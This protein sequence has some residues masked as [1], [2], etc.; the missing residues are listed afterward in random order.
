MNRQRKSLCL[1][2]LIHGLLLSSLYAVSS[3]SAW[4]SAP[5]VIDFSVL[6]GAGPVGAPGPLP[7]GPAASRPAARSNPAPRPRAMA[8]QPPAP[9]APK[10]PPSPALEQPGPAAIVAPQKREAV[11]AARVDGPTNATVP[12]GPSLSSGRGGGGASGGGSVSGS[13]SGGGAGSGTGGGSGGGATADQLRNRYLKEHFAYIRDLIQR[14]ISYP[15]RAR[16]FGWAGKVVVTF[17]VHESGRVSNE[18]VIAS[19]G[20]ELLD[21]N[22]IGTIRDVSPFPKP[23]VK[24]ELRIPIVYRLD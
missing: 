13:G 16:K 17:I 9:V 14:S 22:V 21:N 12:V 19:S 1:S 10:A 11:A 7:A 4:Q 2:L 8:H 20:Y 23:P 6:S 15:A 3:S 5:L 18:R 24:A